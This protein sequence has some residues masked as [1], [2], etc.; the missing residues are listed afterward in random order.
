MFKGLV[1]SAGRQIGNAMH[2]PP[3]SDDQIY[4]NAI[5]SEIR[6]LLD[7]VTGSPAQ[8]IKDLSIPDPNVPQPTGTQ[9]ATVIK[10]TDVL[11]RLNDLELRISVPGSITR[12]DRSFLQVLRDALG[13]MVRPASG[14]T[15]AYTALVVGNLR[16]GASKRTRAARAQIAYANL[17]GPARRHRWAQRV[18]LAMALVLTPC[19]VYESAR[20]A[21]G[22]SILQ[23]VQALN[24]QRTGLSQEVVRLEQAEQQGKV[25]SG[26][27]PDPLTGIV[28]P[29]LVR[30][31]DRPSIAAY[32]LHKQGIAIPVINNGV[33]VTLFE[34]PAQQ[35]ICDRDTVLAADFKV[36][37]AGLGQFDK[38]WAAMIRPEFAGPSGML[39][40][41]N[42]WLDL[43]TGGHCEPGRSSA[44]NDGG[45]DIDFRIAPVLLV[46][47]NYVLP[48]IF[49]TL[50]ATV[51]VILN[52]Y[53][54]LQS[55]LLAPRDNIL[56][57]IRLVLG[58]VLGAC[59][60]L[61]FSASDPAAIPSGAGLAASITLSAS[62]LAFLAGFGVEGVFGLLDTLVRRV[63]S[64]DQDKSGIATTS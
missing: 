17:A 2:P 11:N 1:G 10:N 42:C 32:N 62:G 29:Q 50:G 44:V 46:L 58:M 41:L 43:K 7:Y 5:V 8:T 19:A 51:Y 39:H 23:S 48:I 63:F 64:S 9:E 13:V 4:L 36:A 53:S 49:A 26:G 56:A 20:V 22:R 52:F 3:P 27:V 61:F 14:L 25:S 35:D 34:T 47:G 12:E 24:V 59:V 45:A 18:L 54:K 16:G 37:H 57:W 6:L 40:R 38:D 55:S 28:A 30:L 33:E 31:C 15:I 21:L 60:G